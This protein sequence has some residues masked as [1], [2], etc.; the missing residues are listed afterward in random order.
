MSTPQLYISK[1]CVHCRKLLMILKE[2]PQLRGNFKIVCIDNEPFPN[3]IKS[4]PSM[5]INNEIM[6]SN[7]IFQNI[8]QSLDQQSNHSQQ[9]QQAQIPKP[10]DN[11]ESSEGEIMGICENGFC[12]G[13]ESL[14]S[15]PTNYDGYFASI[16][17]QDQSVNTINENNDGYINNS[18]KTSQFDNDYERMMQERGEVGNGP[19]HGQRPM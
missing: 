2:N 8:Q 14:D 16:D 15:S 12:S 4:V 19:R 5:I 18:K 10:Q 13:F 1:R 6:T 3:V 7:E 9:Q 17:H 11:N